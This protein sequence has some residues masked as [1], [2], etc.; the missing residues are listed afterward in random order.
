M[1]IPDPVVHESDTEAFAGIA[2]SPRGAEGRLRAEGHSHTASNIYLVVGPQG[3]LSNLN[4]TVV[5][6]IPSVHAQN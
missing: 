2:A 6:L 1:I 4:A 5:P 3:S